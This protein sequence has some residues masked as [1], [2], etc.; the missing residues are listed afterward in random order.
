MPV[1]REGSLGQARARVLKSETMYAGPVFGVRKD[2]VVEPGGV[3]VIRDVVTHSGSVVLLP[4]FDDGRVLLVRQYRHAVGTHL[5][6]LVAGR[7]E[8]RES[9]LAA[10]KRE[11]LEETGYTAR[12]FRKLLEIYPSPG[13]VSERML[14]YSAEGL[15]AG[16]ARPEADERIT[17]RH[18][19][20]RQLDTMMRRGSLR[21]AKSVAGILYHARFY[22]TPRR[23]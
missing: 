22:R 21:D 10:A 1:L 3:T 15:T 17:A 9:P 11:L 6:E 12:R 20:L 18:F 14:V 4:L 19:S 13:Y 16:Q 2:R 5:W 7:I 23:K 8:P